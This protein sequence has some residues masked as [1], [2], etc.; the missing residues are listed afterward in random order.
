MVLLH[1]EC[2]SNYAAVMGPLGKAIAEQN[3]V[4]RVIMVL[5]IP[6]SKLFHCE[7]TLYV[8]CC[9]FCCLKEIRQQSMLK[10]KYVAAGLTVYSSLCDEKFNTFACVAVH[11]SLIF[12]S[13][14][15][16]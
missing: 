2:Y 9:P 15:Y 13:S 10:L 16:F 12:S 4:V 14:K 8:V 5:L 11:V 6:L 1:V 7:I 3:E